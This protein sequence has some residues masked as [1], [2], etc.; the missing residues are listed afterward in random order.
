MHAPDPTNEPRYRCLSDGYPLSDETGRRCPECGR[1]YTLE[2]LQRWQGGPEGT[3]LRSLTLL[4]LAT[5]LCLVPFAPPWLA[6]GRQAAGLVVAWAAVLSAWGRLLSGEA[7]L[8]ALAGVFALVAAFGGAAA[9][10]GLVHLGEA[11]CHPAAYLA[12]QGAAAGCLL[13]SVARAA[14]RDGLCSGAESVVTAK[15]LLMAAPL[16]SVLL[17]HPLELESIRDALLYIDGGS[18]ASPMPGRVLASQALAI[19][20]WAVA[21]WR[22][23]GMRSTGAQ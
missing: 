11:V 20:I 4:A 8:A 23:R 14:A 15:L 22:L 10:A 7:Q 3:R 19:G 2:V 12:L 18:R 5:V 1:T 16:G 13:L 6:P 9:P 21:W 17:L